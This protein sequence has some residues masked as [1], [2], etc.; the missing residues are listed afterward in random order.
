MLQTV[1]EL[2]LPAAQARVLLLINHVVARE[3]SALDKLKP[4]AG[5]RL[6]VEAADVPGW[7]PAPPPMRVAI[8]PAGLFE[9]DSHADDEPGDLTLRLSLP[10][11][12]ELLDALAGNAAPRVRIDGA[13]DLAADMHW[14]V[15]NLRWDIEADLAQVLGPTPARLVMSVGRAGANSLRRMFAAPAASQAGDATR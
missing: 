10:T 12:A 9:A 11:P 4:H 13:A 2:L 15:D 8:T 14:L 6:R 3:D 7:L 1:R 5:R